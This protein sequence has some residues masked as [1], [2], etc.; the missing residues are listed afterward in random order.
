MSSQNLGMIYGLLAGALW[1]VTFVIPKLV[2]EASSLLISLIRYSAFGLISIL[3]LVYHRTS[4][5]PY[6]KSKHLLMSCLLALLS[7][8]LYY[9]LVV[10]GIRLVGVPFGSLVVG[11]VPLTLILFGSK[12]KLSR[13]VRESCVLIGIGLLCLNYQVFTTDN[14]SGVSIGGKLLGIFLVFLCLGMWTA[15]GVL[16]SNYLK[17]H[18]EIKGSV[19]TSLIG[20]MSFFTMLLILGV[21]LSIGI[22]PLDEWGGLHSEIQLRLLFWC[23]TSGMLATWVAYTLWNKASQVL[24]TSLLGQLVVFETITAIFYDHLIERAW[25]D[26]AIIVAMIFIV[27]GVFRG[28]RGSR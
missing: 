25:P 13:A 23:L 24:S 16:N 19:W 4:L 22:N 1:G 6:L 11:L 7:N 8:S 10:I 3:T 5:G 14:D 28:I 18:P 20:V 15:Y 2:P 26:L 17:A 12:G 9:I 27:G 21:G